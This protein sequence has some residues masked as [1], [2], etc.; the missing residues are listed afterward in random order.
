MVI[1]IYIVF[2]GDRHLKAC[3]DK[4]DFDLRNLE[5]EVLWSFSSYIHGIVVQSFP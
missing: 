2:K 4:A 1:T 3:L 5:T